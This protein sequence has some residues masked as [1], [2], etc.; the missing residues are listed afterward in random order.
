VLRIGRPQDG[1]LDI[2]SRQHPLP[3]LV[4]AEL[5]CMKVFH[6]RCIGG[7]RGGLQRGETVAAQP[8]RLTD[9]AAITGTTRCNRMKDEG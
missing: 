4:R 6:A 5:H 2:V 1:L 7:C 9:W 8:L 3:A